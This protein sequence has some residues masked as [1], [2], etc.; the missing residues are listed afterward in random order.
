MDKE[1]RNKRDR[2]LYRNN[3]ETKKKRIYTNLKSGS[4]RFLEMAT[5]EHLLELEKLLIQ[6]KISRKL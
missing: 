5:D 2:E 3:E 4:K 1:K 6:E